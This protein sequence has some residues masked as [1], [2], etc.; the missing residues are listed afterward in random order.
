V[1]NWN[2]S[3]T[4]PCLGQHRRYWSGFE[5]ELCLDQH[6]RLGLLKLLQDYLLEA[7]SHSLD[8]CEEL[9]KGKE[10]ER[11]LLLDWPLCDLLLL[12]PVG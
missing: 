4:E 2:G 3:W 9:A 6:H 5:R 12:L 7:D 10:S 11:L 8:L 1:I